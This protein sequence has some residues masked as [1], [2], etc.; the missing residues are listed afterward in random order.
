MMV[1]GGGGREEP[2]RLVALLAEGALALSDV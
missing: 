1:L 2:A